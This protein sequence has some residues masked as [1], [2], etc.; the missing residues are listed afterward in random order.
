MN[1]KA[2]R[3]STMS[4][5]ARNNCTERPLGTIWRRTWGFSHAYSRLREIYG[6]HLRQCWKKE[7][8]YS[9]VIR[10]QLEGCMISLHSG[11]AYFAAIS[12]GG[13]FYERSAKGLER[14]SNQPAQERGFGRRIAARNQRQ[15]TCRLLW[16]CLSRYGSAGSRWGFTKAATCNWPYRDGGLAIS[17]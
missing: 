9:R 11:Y 10:H 12:V 6:L 14:R 7:Q 1:I 17:L 4:L 3:V 5:A 15:R 2:R 8:H 16:R 13:G